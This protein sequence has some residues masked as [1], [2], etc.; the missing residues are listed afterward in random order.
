MSDDGKNE[1]AIVTCLKCCIPGQACSLCY[2]MFS[3]WGFLVLLVS[4][5]SLNLGYRK[6][7]HDGVKDKDLDATTLQVYIAA[8]I[9]L[10]CI[11]GCMFRWWWVT[12]LNPPT[13][14]KKKWVPRNEQN[15]DF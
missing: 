15:S 6:I 14:I 9:Y 11:L 8:A 2:A 10:A 3:V 7:D 5:V 12:Y 13:V 1:S 4:A